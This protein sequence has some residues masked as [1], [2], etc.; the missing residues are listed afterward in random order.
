MGIV[1]TGL[2]YPPSGTVLG[3]RLIEPTWDRVAALVLDQ[4]GH[5]DQKTSRCHL[6]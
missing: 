4:A 2:I 5:L 3:D 1:E 6:I